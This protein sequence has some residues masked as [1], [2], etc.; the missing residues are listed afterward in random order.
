MKPNFKEHSLQELN[1]IMKVIDRESY[2]ERFEELKKELE[3]RDQSSLITDHLE[4]QHF[5]ANEQFSKCPYCAESLGFWTLLTGNLKAD[6]KCQHCGNTLGK[7]LSIKSMTIFF[8]VSIVVH[9]V[10]LRPIVISFGGTP[11]I[12]IAILTLMCTLLSMRWKRIK[13]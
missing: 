12:S 7:G 5:D 2:P 10:L 3:N 9:F 8:F 6:D 13:E 1:D 11:A 4:T